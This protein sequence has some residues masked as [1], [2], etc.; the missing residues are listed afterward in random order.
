MDNFTSKWDAPETSEPKL[1][2]RERLDSSSS[3]RSERSEKNG[4]N[5]DAVKLVS[6]SARDEERRRLLRDVE[7]KLNFEQSKITKINF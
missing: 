3:R 1:A 2:D 5:N 7:V 4:G 6:S